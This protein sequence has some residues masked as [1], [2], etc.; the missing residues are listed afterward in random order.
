MRGGGLILYLT[1]QVLL[2]ARCGGSVA[3][4]RVVAG[5]ALGVLIAVSGQMNALALLSLVAA[6]FA[7]L[8][9]Y[10]RVVDRESRRL[11]RSTE[12][13]TWGSGLR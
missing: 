10:E 11:I 2:R 3:W 5:G 13:A 4:P 7:V 6:V 9:V 12:Q 8:V 1:A